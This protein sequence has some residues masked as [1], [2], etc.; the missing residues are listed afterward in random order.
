MTAPTA[1]ARP[2]A[3]PSGGFLKK[4][5]GPLP[6]WVWM[7]I[8]VALAVVYFQ[9]QKNKGG[10][11]TGDT[12]T[13]TPDQTPPQVFQTMVTLPETINVNDS[14]PTVGTPPPQ[15]PVAGRPV[16]PPKV[17]NP[18]PPAPHPPTPAPG[19]EWVTVAK[20]TT[21]NP[22]WNSTLFGIAKQKLGNGNL[23]PRIW[24]DPHN[25]ALKGRRK[26]PDKIQPGDK[27]WVAK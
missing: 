25:S 6:V 7:L 11:S 12:G 24:G 23:W 16:P 22:P 14:D 26:E 21:R 20:Y 5:L 15:P 13:T 9:Y 3:T 2:P 8:A 19:G 10:S 17:P 27:V 18:P 1:P 4:P